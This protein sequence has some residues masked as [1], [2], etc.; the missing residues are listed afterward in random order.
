[1][2][3]SIIIPTFN[4][5]DNVTTISNRIIQAMEK[6][7]S[8]YEILFVD[9]SKDETPQILDELSKKFSQIKYI[10]RTN[11]RGLG[12]AVVEGFDK[13]RGTY[14]I[15]MDADLQH[16]PELLPLILQRLQEGSDLIIPSRFVEGGS[17]G[18]LNAFRKL[19]SWT[20]RMIGRVSIK[21]MR[22]ITDCTGG[23][24]GLNRNVL[25]NADLD[26]IG[27]KILMEVLVKGNYKTVH[28]I[29]YSFVSRDA[30][31]SKM[32]GKE[33]LNYLRH[34]LK[35]VCSSEEDRKFYIFCLIG[36]SGVLVNLAMLFILVDILHLG[37][38]RSS[39]IA[40]FTAMLSNFILNDTLTWK[41]KKDGASSL[42][43]KFSKFVVVSSVGIIITALFAQFASWLKISIV[44]G[45]MIGIVAATLWNFK[46]NNIWTWSNK[47]E[48]AKQEER[49]IVVSQEGIQLSK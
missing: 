21:R 7:G 12:T 23:F 43:P 35:L 39:I 25:I 8:N 31:E 20:A 17:D 34:I 6:T 44:F 2:D 33:Q 28:E 46:I 5:K 14:I 26:P 13:S 49:R 15:V 22:N 24:F 27:W 11:G 40:S 9:D 10:H 45:Q 3:L 47:E 36:L 1:M 32:S 41:M 16:P 19:V 42:I 29:P 48:L 4:E 37:H 18:G 30:G 38:L